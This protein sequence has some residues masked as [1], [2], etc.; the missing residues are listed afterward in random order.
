MALFSAG[1]PRHT[2]KTIA[3]YK[4]S[5]NAGFNIETCER[6]AVKWPF[7]NCLRGRPSTG[8]LL[9]A[10]K[11]WSIMRLPGLPTGLAAP[12]L[13]IWP[14]LLGLW[15]GLPNSDASLRYFNVGLVP[16]FYSSLSSTPRG[17]WQGRFR[18]TFTGWFTSKICRL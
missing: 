15:I 17:Q 18:N 16:S 8:G 10:A 2:A 7:G 3:D 6:D 4:D 5:A 9:S 14:V 13:R 11:A 12:S 1:P